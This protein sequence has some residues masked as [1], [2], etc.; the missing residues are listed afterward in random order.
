MSPSAPV[1]PGPGCQATD[2][3]A[4]APPRPFRSSS[5][6]G[7]RRPDGTGA[8]PLRGPGQ[9]GRTVRP[10]TVAGSAAGRAPA[11]ERAVGAAAF[12]PPRG[13]DGQG[14]A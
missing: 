10:R 13:L 1:R 8:V 12:G 4:P 9:R 7:A 14:A 6:R 11:A 3:P 5:L 2:L